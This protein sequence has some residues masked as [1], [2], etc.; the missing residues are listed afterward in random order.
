[1][2]SRF[3][4][5]RVYYIMPF[6]STNNWENAFG[7]MID[8]LFF[9]NSITRHKKVNQCSWYMSRS[10]LKYALNERW[11]KIIRGFLKRAKRNKS[12]KHVLMI[13][14][15]RISSCRSL[16][17]IVVGLFVPK[18]K[19]DSGRLPRQKSEDLGSTVLVRA[20]DGSTHV[21]QRWFRQK[22]SKKFETLINVDLQASDLAHDIALRVGQANERSREQ[23]LSKQTNHIG[24]IDQTWSCSECTA[25]VCQIW[26]SVRWK[27]AQSKQ[28]IKMLEKKC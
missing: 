1:M 19:T 26:S 2:E 20:S 25:I 6:N 12:D 28:F 13:L 22:N 8:I 15:W 10:T 14:H 17:L 5:R 18:W 27:G 24:N 21:P 7:R 4:Q 16:L 9:L 23:L 11:K 3:V